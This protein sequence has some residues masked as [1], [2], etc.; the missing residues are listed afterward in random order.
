MKF[1]F[2]ESDITPPLGGIM[3]GY[4]SRERIAVTVHERLY[5]K[6][7]VIQVE[8]A[9]AVIISIDT[10]FVPDEL[11][12]PVTKRIKEYTGINPDCVTIT[13][14]HTHLGAP[15]ENYSVKECWMDEPYFDVMTR[16]VA[17]SAILAYQ[18]LD[19]AEA[20]FGSADVKGLCFCRN[21]IMK[22]GTYLTNSSD[23]DNIISTLEDKIDEE[24]SALFV[25]KDGKKI[26]AIISYPLH[27]DTV[28]PTVLGYSGDYAAIISEKLK[29]EYGHDFVSVF[30]IGT[31]GDVN[32]SDY[33]KKGA[34]NG[35]YCHRKVGTTLADAL[36]DIASEAVPVKGD[37]SQT[38]TTV[39]M[40]R[41]KLTHEQLKEALMQRFDVENHAMNIINIVY[42]HAMG[43]PEKTEVYV[44]VIALGDLAIYLLP[45]EMYSCYGLRIKAESPYKYNLVIENCN[46][47][48]GYIPSLKA[49][50]AE[51][52]LYEA[53]PEIS[54][55]FTPDAGN[56]ITD[57]ALNM[58]EVL[59]KK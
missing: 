46:T 45:G 11:L 43:L 18:R 21:Y 30:G 2:Y 41:R 37:L 59:R 29:E 44:H 34:G 52:R 33:T 25:E 6:A 58:A 15:V 53:S 49:F 23:F 3:P 7:C 22:N 56:I 14:T 48:V 38:K 54:A 8:D 5:S 36:K 32:D 20:S 1:G 42:Y 9:T 4:F 40:T 16:L 13:S 55:A 12:D 19:E 24:L 26:G 50:D 28:S 39:E 47:Q 27:L 17:D 35:C 57:T 10:C 51:S 31:C